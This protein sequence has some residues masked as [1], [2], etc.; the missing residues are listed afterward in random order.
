MINSKDTK[1]IRELILSTVFQVKR[2]MK[3][4]LELKKDINEC[5]D[6]VIREMKQGKI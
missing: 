3:K 1:V 5:F 2:D 4:S 6:I